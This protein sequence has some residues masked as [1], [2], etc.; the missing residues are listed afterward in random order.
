MDET[1]TTQEALLSSSESL[2]N[3]F[4]VGKGKLRI[5]LIVQNLVKLAL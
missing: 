1:T 4:G 5:K 3:H 2:A